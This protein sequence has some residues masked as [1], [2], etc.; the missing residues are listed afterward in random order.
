MAKFKIYHGASEDLLP[1]MKGKYEIVITDPPYGVTYSSNQSAGQGTK[2]IS[3][4]GTRHS[5]RLYRK[6]L[7]LIEAKHML[8]FTRWDAWPDVWEIL[9]QYYPVRGLLVWD[10]GTQGMGDLNHWGPSYELIA[11]VGYGKTNGKRDCSVL[12]YN[13]VPGAY[14]YHPTEKPVDLLCYLIEKISKP[15]DTILDP[16]CGSGSTGVACM[17]T[18]RN[19]IGIE[20]DKS[21]FDISNK[22]INDHINGVTEKPKRRVK[23]LPLQTGM[24]D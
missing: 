18:G 8:W 13:T 6:V 21:N 24:F 10:K 15:G 11:S 12:R 3:N 2:P 7:P 22:R 14:R 19:F 5:L 20:T 23:G 9:G 1:Y 4:D 17:E 16:F